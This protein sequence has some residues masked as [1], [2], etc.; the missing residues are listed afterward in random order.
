MNNVE[1][2]CCVPAIVTRGGSWFKAKG[3]DEAGSKLYCISGHVN[4]PGV[5]EL[6]LGATLD[7]VVEAAG[8]YL[9]GFIFDLTATYVL[10]FLTGVIFNLFNLI[11]VVFMVWRHR[12][13]NRHD[14]NLVTIPA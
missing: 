5:Y 6:E 2:L 8:G 4:R 11:L 10:A 9:G 13:K 3:R 14:T 1:T 12:D 7:E